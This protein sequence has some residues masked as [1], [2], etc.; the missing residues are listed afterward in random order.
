[1]L[2]CYVHAREAN[3]P[4]VNVVKERLGVY[5]IVTVKENA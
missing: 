4:V 1:M 3:A 2:S 5:N